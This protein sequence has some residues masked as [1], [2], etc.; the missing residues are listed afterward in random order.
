MFWKGNT[1]DLLDQDGDSGNGKGSNTDS[2]FSSPDSIQEGDEVQSTNDGTN[3]GVIRIQAE[4]PTEGST[5]ENLQ[6]TSG[7]DHEQSNNPTDTTKES[8]E[9]VGVQNADRRQS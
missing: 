1:A 5:A 8:V 4:N 9:G 6:D 3:G 7:N 2:T